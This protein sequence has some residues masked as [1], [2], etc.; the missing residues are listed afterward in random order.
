M[1]SLKL[2]LGYDANNFKIKAGV[3][4]NLGNGDVS[5]W[6]SSIQCG[7]KVPLPNQGKSYMNIQVLYRYLLTLK[8]S[9]CF[10]PRE[11][12]T[13]NHPILLVFLSAFSRVEKLRSL[14]CA[15][16]H[17]AEGKQKSCL[18]MDGYLFSAPLAHS[19]KD[20]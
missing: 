1:P 17:T 8:N 12:K 10:I 14:L 15:Y 19:H 13:N 20:D 9:V 7:T 5:L 16:F 18:I 4:N 3:R 11:M 2:C 6:L